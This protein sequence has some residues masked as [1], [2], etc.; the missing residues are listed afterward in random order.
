MD[1]DK[2]INILLEVMALYFTEDG[3]PFEDGGE[4]A[5]LTI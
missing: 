3:K 4:L 5:R 2:V 1:K